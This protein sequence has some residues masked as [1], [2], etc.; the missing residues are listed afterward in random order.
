MAWNTRE[1]LLA[2]LKG[3][4]PLRG[5][6]V[7]ILVVDNASSDGSA[8]AVR[9]AF[10]E[11]LLLPQDHN[12]GFAFGVN[13]GIE[14]ARGEFILLL[15][16]DVDPDPAAISALLREARENGSAGIFGPRIVDGRGV[17][18]PSCWRDPRLLIHAAD[19]FGANRLRR[20][21]RIS[22][23]G[24]VDCVSGCVLLIARR[25]IER[26]GGMDERFFMYFEESDFCRRARK[27]GFPV[28]LLSR[29]EFTHAGG[30]SA[31]KARLRTFLAFRESCLAYHAAWDGRLGAEWVRFWLLVGCALRFCFWAPAAALGLPNKARLYAAAVKMLA[32]PSLVAG[33]ARRARQVPMFSPREA[34]AG[35]S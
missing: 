8:A 6:D 7:E 12:G 34:P 23:E 18:Q 15:N 28:R 17:A 27:A 2:L 14:H 20:G 21:A 11:V 9:H 25:V 4:A 10:P 5:S 1:L 33:I 35:G 29:V 13:R 22:S 24:A 31:E 32:R 26:I 30:L 3:L 19:A 16:P